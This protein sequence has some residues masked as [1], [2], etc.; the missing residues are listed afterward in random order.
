MYAAQKMEHS[1]GLCLVLWPD[2]SV[3]NNSRDGIESVA[4]PQ[5]FYG[6]IMNIHLRGVT[7][8]LTI[9]TD[10]PRLTGPLRRLLNVSQHGNVRA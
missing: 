1:V 10:E 5:I 6:P 2:Q 3:N 4:D 7:L 8:R 9:K